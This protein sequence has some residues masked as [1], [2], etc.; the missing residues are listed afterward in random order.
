MYYWWAITCGH[1]ILQIQVG[2]YQDNLHL[3]LAVRCRLFL[4]PHAEPESDRK[5]VS[6]NNESLID[7]PAISRSALEF[8]LKMLSICIWWSFQTPVLSL[9]SVFATKPHRTGVLQGEHTPYT[10]NTHT[11]ALSLSLLLSLIHTHVH[12][13][14]HRHTRALN[15]SSRCARCSAKVSMSNSWSVLV[16]RFNQVLQVWRSKPRKINIWK[17]GM[18]CVYKNKKLWFLL[19]VRGL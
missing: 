10:H 19:R 2:L 3:G 1:N 14:T 11:N 8:S 15:P 9:S 4:L 7:F 12:T 17:R 16:Y 6:L 13:H 18:P 5:L